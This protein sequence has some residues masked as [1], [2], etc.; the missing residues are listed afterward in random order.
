MVSK[1]LESLNKRRKGAWLQLQLDEIHVS[2]LKLGRLASKRE[3]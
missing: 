2:A 3:E 1:R